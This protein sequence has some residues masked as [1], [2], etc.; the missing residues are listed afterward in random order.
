MGFRKYCADISK[1]ACVATIDAGFDATT[2]P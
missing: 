2:S 1:P